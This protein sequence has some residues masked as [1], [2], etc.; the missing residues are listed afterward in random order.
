MFCELKESF[1]F[2]GAGHQRK[3]FSKARKLWPRDQFL[4]D[5]VF[6][7]S[8]LW[9]WCLGLGFGLAP[10][11]EFPSSPV[12]EYSTQAQRSWQE[13]VVAAVSLAWGPW[14][15]NSS[16]CIQIG[17]R[18][19]IQAAC[20][21]EFVLRCVCYCLQPGSELQHKQKFSRSTGNLKNPTE[22]YT[23]NIIIIFKMTFASLYLYIVY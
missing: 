12:S 9:L 10:S 7:W 22:F 1:S 5:W 18:R 20:I 14:H 16:A 11:A 8:W 19:K 15:F 6:S 13:A 21:C 3:N 17:Q 23:I 2:S 4:V